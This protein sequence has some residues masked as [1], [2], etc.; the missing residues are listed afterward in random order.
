M[1]TCKPKSIPPYGRLLIHVCRHHKESFLQPWH[2]WHCNTS[3]MVD[4]IKCQSD[5]HISVLLCGNIIRGVT[6]IWSRSTSRDIVII[7]MKIEF[8]SCLNYLMI[9][10]AIER[11][12]VHFPTPILW[13][14]WINSPFELL[15]LKGVFFDSYNETPTLQLLR[16]V[17]RNGTLC[18]TGVKLLS[19]LIRLLMP[20]LPYAVFW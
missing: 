14:A 5:I 1:Q 11:F 17:S 16:H 6:W 3:A 4:K 2:T 15:G 8:T 7:G 20:Q 18:G 13:K 10:F 9:L 12:C 19:F